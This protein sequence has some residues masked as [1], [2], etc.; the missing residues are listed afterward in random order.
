MKYAMILKELLRF[1]EASPIQAIAK[2]FGLPYVL[3]STIRF[4]H[5]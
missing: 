3:Y 2:S 4:R 5:R 1:D